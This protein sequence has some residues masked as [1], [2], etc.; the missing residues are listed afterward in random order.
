MCGASLSRGV[1]PCL[2]SRPLSSKGVRPT[3]VNGNQVVIRWNFTFE[4]HDSGFV[5]MNELTYRRWEGEL[6][7]RR[8]V[9]FDPAQRVQKPRAG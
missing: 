8:D 4:S 2:L 9:F 1:W 3:F 6:H 5:V 7:P